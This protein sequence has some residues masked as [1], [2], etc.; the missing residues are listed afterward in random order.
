MK[1]SRQ[2]IQLCIKLVA[3]VKISAFEEGADD[4]YTVLCGARDELFLA[5]KEAISEEAK[6][7]SQ[8][9]LQ[10]RTGSEDSKSDAGDSGSAQEGR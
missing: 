1:L 7:G 4:A 10:K 8:R 2:T 6:N 3:D 9:K 5:L